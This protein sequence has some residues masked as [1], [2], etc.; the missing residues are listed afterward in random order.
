MIK[1]SYFYENGLSIVLPDGKVENIKRDFNEKS[2]SDLFLR[3]NKKIPGL[4]E[5]FNLDPKISGGY[6]FSCYLA[7]NNNTVFCPSNV[8]D[9]SIM[10]VTMPK[11]PSKNQIKEIKRLFK[12]LKNQ[13]VYVLLCSFKKKKKSKVF[14]DRLSS[15]GEFLDAYD[16]VMNYLNKIEAIND[17]LEDTKNSEVDVSEFFLDNSKKR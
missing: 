5:G 9:N 7:A 17:I 10:I 8:N 1:D 15:S 13:E 2:H 4:L 6:E 16:K 3:A 14:I 11:Y 12:E